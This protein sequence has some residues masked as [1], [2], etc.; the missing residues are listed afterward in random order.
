MRVYDNRVAFY[1]TA[2]PGQVKYEVAQ[3]VRSAGIN[4]DG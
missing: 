3:L 1:E 2:Y 4:F